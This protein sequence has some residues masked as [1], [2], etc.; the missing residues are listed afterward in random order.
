MGVLPLR[1]SSDSTA[2]DV[3]WSN[4]PVSC[5]RKFAHICSILKQW[6]IVQNSNRVTTNHRNRIEYS[7]NIFNTFTFMSIRDEF[8]VD[9]GETGGL[10]SAIA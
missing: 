3:R 9:S 6:S 8:V 2:V 7:G 1:L 4:F 10:K 5:R